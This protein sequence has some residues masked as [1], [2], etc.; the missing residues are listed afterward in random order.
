MSK[1]STPSWEAL[2]DPDFLADLEHWVSV[3]RATALRTLLLVKVVLR[4][5]FTGIGKPEAL[6]GLG[7]GIWSRRI[8]QE[9]RL[10]YR[11][12]QSRIYFLQARY[13]YH[14]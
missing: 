14:K 4:D 12:Q 7:T 10:V 2:F 1:P 11:I 9:H 5:P 13:H 6:K 8:N 3:D